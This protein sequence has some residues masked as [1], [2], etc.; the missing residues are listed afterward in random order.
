MSID[1]IAN[2]NLPDAGKFKFVLVD[3]TDG[4]RTKPVLVAGPGENHRDIV[5]DFEF[6]L[7]M[8]MWLSE[9]KGGGRVELNPGSIYAFGESKWYG[10]APQ[11]QVEN[12]LR[13][14]VSE[15]K[16]ETTVKVQM[17]VGY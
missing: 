3:V 7:P 2:V 17:G 4:E 1:E 5:K 10:M 8:E 9:I 13:A 16:P 12:L 15:Q 11:D 14:Y 6:S